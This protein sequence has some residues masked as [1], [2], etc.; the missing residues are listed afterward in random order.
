MDI[1][2]QCVNA[3]MVTLDRCAGPMQ[4][5]E[6]RQNLHRHNGHDSPPLLNGTAYSPEL[7]KLWRRIAKSRSVG[8]NILQVPKLACWI[9]IPEFDWNPAAPTF[10]VC[11]ARAGRAESV[12]AAFG[13]EPGAEHRGSR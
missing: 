1:G 5:Q 6:A 7:S 9:R 10:A 8:G 12:N 13:N 11:W 2:E 3:L 4:L